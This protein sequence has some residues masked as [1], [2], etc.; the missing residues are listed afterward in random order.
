MLAKLTPVLIGAAV[1]I[2]V[3]ALSSDTR[4]ARADDYWNNYWGSYD[5]HYGHRDGRRHSY[6]RGYDD[7]DWGYGRSYYPRSRYRSDYYS[8]Y[9]DYD[10]DYGYGGYYNRGYWGRPYRY[11]DDGGSIG[12]GPFQFHWR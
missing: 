7:D 11:Y 6:Y 2:A 5:R 1:L 12:L 3:L 9:Y 10:Y 4:V 8:P